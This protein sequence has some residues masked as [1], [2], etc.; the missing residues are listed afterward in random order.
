MRRNRFH[1][2]LLYFSDA[3]LKNHRTLFCQIALQTIE[4]RNLFLI[5]HPAFKTEMSIAKRFFRTWE[6]ADGN[7]YS[8]YFARQLLCSDLEKLLPPAYWTGKPTDPPT[9]LDPPPP[10][11]AILRR[12]RVA[13]D[14]FI[15]V[16]SPIPSPSCAYQIPSASR[17]SRDPEFDSTDLPHGILVLARS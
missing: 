4:L 6:L 16:L 7:P 13:R 12:W 15:M 2:T 11:T 5:D 17:R 8:V 14:V 3:F 10:S 1:G 9:D